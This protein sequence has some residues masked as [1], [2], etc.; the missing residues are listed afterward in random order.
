MS[1]LPSFLGFSGL[2]KSIGIDRWIQP[3]DTWKKTRPYVYLRRYFLEAPISQTIHG[4]TSW[5]T[6]FTKWNIDLSGLPSFIELFPLKISFL[7][8]VRTLLTLFT[9][10]VL[11]IYLKSFGT[12]SSWNGISIPMDYRV[13]LGFRK[14]IGIELNAQGRYRR[15]NAKFTKSI[16]GEQFFKRVFFDFFPGIS[17]SLTWTGRREVSFS[18]EMI[19]RAHLHNRCCHCLPVERTPSPPLLP[20]AGQLRP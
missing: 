3:V 14:S 15:W 17:L 11:K 2:K 12:Q 13:L 18:L 4:E 16:F 1:I 19:G 6:K 8:L 5:N 10:H 20:P 9:S 7:R